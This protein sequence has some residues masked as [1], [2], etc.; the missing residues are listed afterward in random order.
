MSTTSRPA[1][2]IRRSTQVYVLVPSSSYR[3][4]PI[5]RK[6]S[7]SSLESE[8]PASSPI[9]LK[10]NTPLRP[11]RTNSELTSMTTLS[12]LSSKSN[13]RK[14]VEESDL[15]LAEEKHETKG[16][17]AKKPRVSSNSGASKPTNVAKKPKA[18]SKAKTVSEPKENGDEY[19]NGFFYCHQCTKKRDLSRKWCILHIC[20]QLI[21]QF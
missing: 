20:R 14:H 10:E 3:A 16:P 6:D 5:S 19:P 15:P 2:V 9:S 17:K 1:S 8:S 4:P 13:K 12:T 7:L 11:T 21:I 18:T